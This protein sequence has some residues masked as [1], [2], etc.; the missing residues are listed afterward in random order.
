MA[1]YTAQLHS[2]SGSFA[3]PEGTQSLRHANNL[4]NLTFFLENW[5]ERHSRVG[6]DERDAYLVV[7]KGELKDVTDIYPDFVLKYGPRMGIVREPV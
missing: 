7:W 2:D 6:S 1:K 5:A 3:H 4:D